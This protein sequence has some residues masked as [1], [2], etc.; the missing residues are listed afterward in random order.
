MDG[1]THLIW[2]LIVF[3]WQLEDSV[4]TYDFLVTVI[5]QKNVDLRSTHVHSKAP[6]PHVYL[7][8]LAVYQLYTSQN[9]A[10]DNESYSF[11]LST[12]VAAATYGLR[13]TRTLL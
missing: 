5:Q 6:I 11:M 1:T 4:G 12:N 13:S 3:R 9:L 2:Q 8:F 10:C 7:L